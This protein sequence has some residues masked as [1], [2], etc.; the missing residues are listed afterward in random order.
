MHGEARRVKLLV[1]FAAGGGLVLAMSFGLTRLAL[2]SAVSSAANIPFAGNLD[3]SFGSGGVVTHSHAA[4]Q[5]AGVGGVV[6]QPDGK[7]VVAVGSELLAR[8]LSNGS[9]DPSFG[10][11]GFVEN[12]FTYPAFMRAVVLQP[13]GKIVV[14]GD[15]FLP[16]DPN[17]VGEFMLARYNPDG[18]LDSSFGTGGVTNTAFPEPGPSWSASADALV[19]LP[20]GKIVAGGTAGWDDGAFC[21][22]P[23]MFA[24]ARYTSDG[25]LDA[26]FGDGGIVQTGFLGED[27]FGGIAV[28]PDGK[29]VASGS[30]DGAACPRPPPRSH[31][32]AAPQPTTIALVRYDSDGSLDPSFGTGGKVTTSP[33]ASYYGGAGPPVLEDGKILVVG[34]DGDHS[35]SDFLVLLRYRTGGSLDSIAEIRHVIAPPTAVL[36][37]KD[38]KILI[39][40]SNSEVVRLLPSGRRDNSFGSGGIVSLPGAMPPTALGLQRDRKI[41]VGSA[42]AYPYDTWRLARLIGGNNCIVPDLGDKTISTATTTLKTSY[43]RRGRISARFSSRVRRG[44]VISTT[45]RR[46]ARLPGGTKVDLVVSNGKRP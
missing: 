34:G 21:G 5:P 7:I 25:V 44:R 23:S 46:G 28:Q 10:N 19:V 9:P 18:S 8:Y 41:L 26:T 14:A 36:A 40:V 42:D 15:S 4:N 33:A 27:Q 3:P 13:D 37:Q 6:V 1:G 30:G 45:P 31:V 11:G 16:G 17:P 38:G 35:G 2:D 39:A 20:D 29:I 24:L 12:Q 43:C 22:P 32:A